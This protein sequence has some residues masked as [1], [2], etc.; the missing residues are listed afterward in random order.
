MTTTPFILRGRRPIPME[1]GPLPH[2]E[3]D[4]LLQVWIDRRVGEPVVRVLARGKPTT[5]PA[6]RRAEINDCRTDSDDS[7]KVIGPS[8][9]GETSFTK[10]LEGADTT[11][12]IRM[13]PFG[14]TI[15]TQAV[16][17]IDQPPLINDA[18]EGETVPA[19]GQ[20]DDQA[21]TFVPPYS[22]F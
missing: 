22:H 19:A 10:T 9:F 11:E 20:T 5:L 14:E 8:P 17:G 1:N 4:P 7:N 12:G 18:D 6:N 21:A 15:K 16:E 13:T 3:Y 2:H